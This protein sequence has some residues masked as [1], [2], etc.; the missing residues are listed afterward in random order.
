MP[1]I[2]MVLAHPDDEV[3]LGG[4]TLALYARRGVHT[5][6]LCFTLGQAGRTGVRG[7]KPLATHETIGEVR[8]DE[9]H[10]A[11][12]KLGI[13]ELIAPG[14]ADGELAGIDDAKGAAAVAGHVRR[15][16]PEV[17]ISFGEEGAPSAHPDH[18]AICRWTTLGYELAA[19]PS[20]P[21]G[22]PP[23]EVRKHYWLTWP[24]ALDH[25]RR[26]SGS[27]TTTIIDLGEQIG[28][29]KRDAFAEHRTQ[30]DHMELYTNLQDGLDNKEHLHLAQSRVGFPDGIESDL[31][32]RI[33]SP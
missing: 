33:G 1:G 15:I 8:R 25:L 20:H 32:E 12:Q 22:L 14:W 9:L 27:E 23:C 6:Y 7:K 30:H 2:L 13:H 29:L 5:A 18:K 16:K 28:Q 11:V 19:D 24:P 4:G 31:F 17:L 26:V 10:R 21:S 3:F